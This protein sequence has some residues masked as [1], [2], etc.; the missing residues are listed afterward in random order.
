MKRRQEDEL[1]PDE[2]HR[3]TQKL[4]PASALETG[5]LK[6]E[7]LEIQILAE[8]R[9]VTRK[10]VDRA[11]FR[12]NFFPSLEMD[13]YIAKAAIEAMVSIG[14]WNWKESPFLNSL[15]ALLTAYSADIDGAFKSAC[16]P[17]NC[18]GQGSA[19]ETRLCAAF[20]G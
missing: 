5:A 16:S 2:T 3:K 18:Q 12:Q 19:I 20:C 14:R 7:E 11:T 8:A 1:A 10:N 15:D 13:D 4:S 6:A 9:G 17:R